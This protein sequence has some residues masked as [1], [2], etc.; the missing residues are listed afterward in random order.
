MR[1]I[2]KV[3]C[4]ALGRPL[5][6]GWDKVVPPPRRKLHDFIHSQRL[7]ECLVKSKIISN[8]RATCR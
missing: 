5:I 8:P 4:E 7:G 2:R 1:L 6:D 3:W